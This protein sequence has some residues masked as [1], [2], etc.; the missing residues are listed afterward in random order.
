MGLMNRLVRPAYYRA[1]RT[2]RLATALRGIA[3]SAAPVA[4][5]AACDGYNS[6]GVRRPGNLRRLRAMRQPKLLPRVLHHERPQFVRGGGVSPVLAAL[7][8]RELLSR[9]RDMDVRPPSTRQPNASRQGSTRARLGLP[10]YLRA[11]A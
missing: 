1:W 2:S 8:R 7:Q 5:W 11:F 10:S 4:L 6:G 3:A 9:A